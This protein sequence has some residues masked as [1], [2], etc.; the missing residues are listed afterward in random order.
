MTIDA[1][2]ALKVAGALGLLVAGKYVDRWFTKK[3]KLVTYIG[4]VS[5]F[6]VTGEHPVRVNT[7]AIVVLN[8]GRLRAT[9][10]RIGHHLV[11]DNFNVSPAVAHNLVVHNDGTAEIV[12]ESLIPNE[13]V[14]ISYLYFPP[15]VWTQFHSFTRSD[16]G[17]AKVITAIPTPRFS[18]WTLLGLRAL[19]FVGAA[20]LIYFL[21]EFVAWLVSL[22]HAIHDG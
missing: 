2:L 20:T 15:L 14:T 7:H 9:N 17:F 18:R 19:C 22:R 3:P 8:S 12:F 5:S 10:V 13:Q 6:N 16:E 4:H 11:P 1:D 21:Y